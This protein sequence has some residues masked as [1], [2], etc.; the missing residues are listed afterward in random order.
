VKNQLAVGAV[1]SW[2]FA[3]VCRDTN[4]GGERDRSALLKLEINDDFI[5]E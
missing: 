1:D 5:V 4:C 3:C 2:Q